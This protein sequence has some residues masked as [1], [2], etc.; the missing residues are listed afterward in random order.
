MAEIEQLPA[1]CLQ[2]KGNFKRCAAIQVVFTYFEMAQLIQ[3]QQLSR[4]FYNYTLPGIC[5][6]LKIQQGQDY[7]DL[8][9]K[10][11]ERVMIFSK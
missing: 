9:K 5:P 11:I 2:Y 4:R 10:Q 8:M 7:T 6:K 3:M 1:Y